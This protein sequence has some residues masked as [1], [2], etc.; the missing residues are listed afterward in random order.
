MQIKKFRDVTVC[1]GL[2]Q[3]MKPQFTWL[4]LEH[5]NVFAINSTINIFLMSVSRQSN[6]CY[7]RYRAALYTQED[8]E[9]KDFELQEDQEYFVTQEPST[10][11]MEAKVTS[12]P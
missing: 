10:Q 8:K 9:G 6:I 7:W 12:L 4:S 11:I 1:C 5:W 3:R 2:V